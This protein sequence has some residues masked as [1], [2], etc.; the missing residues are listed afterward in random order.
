MEVWPSSEV[1]A[2]VKAFLRWIFMRELVGPG[3]EVVFDDRLL[4]TERKEASQARRSI[5][6]LVSK[7]AI[8]YSELGSFE[9]NDRHAL[10]R[11]YDAMK[12]AEADVNGLLDLFLDL[13]AWE[14]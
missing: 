12:E 13:G 3:G 14:S 2:E 11:A 9:D 8:V 5:R 7:L 1:L 6:E 10:Q 4:P